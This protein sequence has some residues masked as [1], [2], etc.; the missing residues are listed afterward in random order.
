MMHY[1]FLKEAESL[2]L[3]LSSSS[4]NKKE[5]E[6]KEEEN[7]DDDDGSVFPSY[8]YS[9]LNDDYLVWKKSKEFIL[10]DTYKNRVALQKHFLLQFQQQQGIIM[11]FFLSIAKVSITK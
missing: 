11:M 10:Y 1:V 9:V 2:I 3:S 7:T 4:T 6:E 8:L 5:D